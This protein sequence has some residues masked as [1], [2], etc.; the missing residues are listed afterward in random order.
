MRVSKDALNV[1][2]ETLPTL[3]LNSCCDRMD[4]KVLLYFEMTRRLS[5]S[6]V[7]SQFGKYSFHGQGRLSLG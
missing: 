5:E 3:A 1:K 4:S 2:L 6:L 7:S